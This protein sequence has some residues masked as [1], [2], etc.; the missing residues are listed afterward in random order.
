MDFLV[1]AFPFFCGNAEDFQCGFHSFQILGPSQQQNMYVTHMTCIV[2]F[3][4][5]F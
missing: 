2:D 1:A 3:G 4:M 5:D